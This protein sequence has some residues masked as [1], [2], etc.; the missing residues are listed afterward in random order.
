[1]NT[2]EEARTGTTEEYLTICLNTCIHD[3]VSVCQTLNL[4]SL[5]IVV[6]QLSF[7]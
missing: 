5:D 6:P 4:N 7:G 3:N 1:M 2:A